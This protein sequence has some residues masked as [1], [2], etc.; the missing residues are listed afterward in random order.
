MKTTSLCTAIN[1]K[2]LPD[3][4]IT[5][6]YD[7]ILLCHLSTHAS[8]SYYSRILLP[9]A[10]SLY[11]S[12]WFPSSSFAVFPSAHMF[13]CFV[14]GE[15]PLWPPSR[16]GGKGPSARINKQMLYAS[17]DCTTG[18]KESWWA[19]ERAHTDTHRRTHSTFLLSTCH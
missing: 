18:T 16:P 7:A 19:S 6:L 3:P 11:L 9:F 17:L 2:H 10:R 14:T 8:S 4:R 12:L 1:M 15:T 5:G 13:R